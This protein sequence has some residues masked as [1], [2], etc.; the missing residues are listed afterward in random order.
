MVHAHQRNSDPDPGLLIMLECDLFFRQL[1]EQGFH[2]YA[3]VPD[4]LL[5]NFCAYVTDHADASSHIIAANEGNAV[6][7]ASGHTL[8]TNEPAVVYL[9]NSGLGNLVNP[10]TSLADP[11]VYSIP[12]LLLIGWRGEPGRPDEPQ[13]VKQGRINNDLLD[14]LEIPWAVLPEEA[15]AAGETLAR[16][17]GVMRERSGP[18]ALVVR[19]G[20]FG[21]Y[22]LQSAHIQAGLTLSREAAIEQVIKALDPHTIV[23]STTGK[24]SR[25][26]FEIRKASA[27]DGVT[28]DF[29]TVGSMGHSSQIALGIAL[30]KPDR[31]VV[32]I[33]GDGALIMH[34]GG[35]G[36]IGERQPKNLYHIVV[37]NG[38]HESVGGQPTVGFK[39]DLPAIATACGYPTAQRVQ[40]AEGLASVLPTF[41]SETGPTFLEIQVTLGSREDLAR[42][43]RSPR[44]NKEAFMRFVQES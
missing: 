18:V 19:K 9:Q 41:L 31:R 25:E 22:K 27:E 16:M 44:E 23:V 36:I 15:D 28:R 14:A 35:L 3:G 11:E 43:D 10:L 30:A 7:L 34:M 40:S 39:L 21:P 24:P 2:F 42:P 1:S 20:T 13:H 4:S 12:M 38:A 17:A 6:A 5:K 32:I 26:V 37:N 8:A 33:D 29:L